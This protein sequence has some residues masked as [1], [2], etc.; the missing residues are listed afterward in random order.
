M[1]LCL[2]FIAFAAHRF[3]IICQMD[4]AFQAARR[5]AASAFLSFS[6]LPSPFIRLPFVG[7]YL[8]LLS[9]IFCQLPPLAFCGSFS[10]LTICRLPF[11]PWPSARLALLFGLLQCTADAFAA[12]FFPCFCYCS[13]FYSSVTLCSA[14]VCS[15]A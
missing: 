12:P 8:N 9:G 2:T 13:Y 5:G 15:F 1:Q 14:F 6:C 7:T 3:K 11:W 10:Q 4:L